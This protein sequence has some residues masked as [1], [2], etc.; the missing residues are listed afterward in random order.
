MLMH[1]LFRE[2][3]DNAMLALHKV[4]EK[5]IAANPNAI[6]C[7]RK[8]DCLVYNNINNMIPTSNNWGDVK[9]A[10]LPKLVKSIL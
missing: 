7:G 1:C 9:V 8:V 5:V 6:L 2:I 10:Q 4:H 3:Y